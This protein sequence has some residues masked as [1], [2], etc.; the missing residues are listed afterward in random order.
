MT[1]FTQPKLKMHIIQLAVSIPCFHEHIKNAAL[2]LWQCACRS[3]QVEKDFLK[4][5]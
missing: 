4:E 5:K 2:R 3:Q 1:T